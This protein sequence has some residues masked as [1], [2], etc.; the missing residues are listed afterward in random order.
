MDRIIAAIRS[1]HRAAGHKPPD[2]MGARKVVLGYRA[3]LSERKDPAAKPRKA[4]PADRTVL[5]RALAKLDRTTLA[6]QRDAALMLLGHAL[7]SRGSELVP[8]NIPDSF[9]DLP[10]GGFSVEVYRKKR[11]CWQDVTIVLDP[12]PTSARSALSASSSPPSPT[13]AT[14]PGPSSCAWTAGATSPRPCT[15]TA[16]PSETPPAA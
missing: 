1:A 2:T 11:K 9:T 10:D 5:R 14:T 13:T 4:T 15:A 3:E 16:S 8:L 6:G 12:D 7:A